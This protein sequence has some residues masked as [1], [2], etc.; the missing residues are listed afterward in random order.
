M[1]SGFWP[2]AGSPILASVLRSNT[3]TLFAPRDTYRW[4]RWS[5]INSFADGTLPSNVFKGSNAA[6]GALITYLLPNGGSSTASI[7]ILDANGRT[8]R[9]LG[10]KDVPHK[11]GLNR[12]A[13]DLDEDGPVKWAGTYEPNQGPAEGAE[14]LPGTYTVR[15]HANGVVRDQPVIVEA[16]PRD[17]SALQEAQARHDTLAELF[18]E[19]GGVDTMLNALDRRMKA[20][21]STNRGALWAF[22]QRL[23]YDPRN[24]EDLSG[25][26]GVRERLLDLIYRISSS[27]FQAPTSAQTDVATAL[28]QAC[29]E[30]GRAYM[31]LPH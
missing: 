18:A 23:T 13:W 20:G 2:V 11:A 27:S 16:D 9:H 30:I 5:P 3:V 21:V 4:W 12:V 6:Y 28:K 8:I 22:R 24:D 10:A 19:L 17:P 31:A 7:E 25:P 1:A 26:P 29:D 14:V 15:L